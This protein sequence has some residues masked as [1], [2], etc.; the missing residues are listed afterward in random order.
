[1]AGLYT[2]SPVGDVSLASRP[3]GKPSGKGKGGDNPRK[4]PSG[5][6]ILVYDTFTDTGGTTLDA[7]IPDIDTVGGGWIRHTASMIINASGQCEEDINSTISISTIDA[8]NANTIITADCWQARNSADRANTGIV[9]RFSDINNFW[10]LILSS[11]TPAPWE[12]TLQ[13][14][15]AGVA[16][17]PFVTAGTD[18]TG[19]IDSA[20]H[21]FRVTLS[22]DTIRCEIPAEGI[23]ETA[24]P[25]GVR[26]RQRV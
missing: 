17:Y 19:S 23:D 10:A 3:S 22:G 21:E 20:L 25:S 5:P 16:S 26:Y 7:H 9:F 15:V 13:K 1:M 24:T 18:L 8:G 14:M 4:G 11:S 12:W 6:T 2:T